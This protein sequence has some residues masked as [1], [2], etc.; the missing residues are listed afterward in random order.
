MTAVARRYGTEVDTW[1]IWNEPNHP[2]FLMPQ[3]TGTG[4]NKRPASPAI[5]RGL[6][7]AAIT[8]LKNAG[9]GADRVL[10]GETAPRGTGSAV[11]PLKF[12]RGASCLS[13]SW[14]RRRGCSQ[15]AVDG[16]AHHAYTTT[17]GPWFR[18]SQPNDVTIGTLDRLIS[19]LDRAGRTGALPKHLPIWLTEF[20]VQSEPD[21]YLG[22]SFA[23]QAEYRSI[24]EWLAYRQRRVRAFS[25]YLM[26]DDE[27]RAGSSAQRYSGFESGLRTA[28]GAPK[29]AYEGFRL[30][31]M[32]KRRAHDVFLWGLVRP[33]NGVEQ[34]TVDYRNGGSST[35]HPL[36][37]VT[38][39]NAG[40]WSTTTSDR[41]RTYRVRWTGTV[42]TSHTGPATRAY[43]Q[44]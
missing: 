4:K 16:Y 11:S 39:S 14:K 33:H 35:W 23:K 42:S 15:L 43:L 34:V 3:Y 6:L 24:S 26:R 7:Q 19:A 8:G 30:P 1:A 37:V 21:P 9:Q 40:Y 28:E 22:V 25:Q 17:A 27:P 29:P 10:M 44:R 20:G 12:L 31:L 5:Y 41:G 18:P 13:E 38:T 36:K 32:A 2:D